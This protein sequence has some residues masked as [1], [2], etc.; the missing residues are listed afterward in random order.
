MTALDLSQGDLEERCSDPSGFRASL[1]RAGLIPAMFPWRG[2]GLSLLCAPCPGTR[3]VLL[4]HGVT[5]SA[6]SVFDLAV[7]GHDRAAFS[8]LMQLSLR[9][10]DA[11]A[12]DFAGY[13][14]SGPRPDA[15]GETVDDYVAQVLAAIDKIETRTGRTPVLL[16]WSWGAQVACRLAGRHPGRCSGL[17]FWSGLW[18]GTGGAAFVRS[19]SLPAHP[20][21]RNTAAHA[22]ADFRTPAAYDPEVRDA[23]VAH[24]LRLD[25]TSPTTGL[26]ETIR[27]LPLH[28]PAR[29]TCPTL[30]I[31]GEFDPVANSTDT[32]DFVA[33][34]PAGLA[35]HVRLP[36]A[37]H[38]AQFGHTRAALFD[39]VAAFCHDRA[40]DPCSVL[41]EVAR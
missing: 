27:N 40:A 41:P 14:L 26:T 19:L 38:N 32:N 22:A 21:R 5:Y 29:V 35:R 25:P 9:G 7:P 30:V 4:L 2:T 6:A 1:A 10:V 28:D 23:F 31:H 11:W 39:A 3:P 13:G 34:L 16:G 37:D 18:G 33:A 15:F 36:G 20:R 8:M 24:A 17:V 12:L